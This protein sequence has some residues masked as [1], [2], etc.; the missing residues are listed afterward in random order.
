[1]H[2]YA[3]THAHSCTHCNLCLHALQDVLACVM[4]RA[5]VEHCEFLDVCIVPDVCINMYQWERRHWRPWL[6]GC[7]HDLQV[8]DL[9]GSVEG[10]GGRA[11][12]ACREGTGRLVGRV[13]NSL[14]V[15][16]ARGSHVLLGNVEIGVPLPP[17]CWLTRFNYVNFN[18]VNGGQD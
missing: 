2:T 13:P 15:T 8:W 9:W 17:R 18:Y 16:S 6:H 10:R 14:S 11:R 4:F 12:L 1:M 7:L 5:C 3:H